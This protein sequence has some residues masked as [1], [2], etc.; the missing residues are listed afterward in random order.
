[1][2]LFPDVSYA[3]TLI[4]W[5]KNAGL[6]LEIQKKKLAERVVKGEI[7]FEVWEKLRADLEIGKIERKKNELLGY[8]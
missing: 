8:G 6:P 1:M 5:V 3:T 2:V 7:P 4:A